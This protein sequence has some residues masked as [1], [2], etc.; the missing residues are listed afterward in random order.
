LRNQDLWVHNAAGVGSSVSQSSR[1]K[2]DEVI[3]VIESY[4][5]QYNSNQSVSANRTIYN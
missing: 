3:S 4:I 1:I 2:Q 5:S